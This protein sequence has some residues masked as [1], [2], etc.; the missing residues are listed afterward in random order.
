MVSIMQAIFSTSIGLI[1]LQRHCTAAPGPL[2]S[3]GASHFVAVVYAWF[4]APYFFYDITSMFIVFQLRLQGR[5]NA[6]KSYY[7]INLSRNLGSLLSK[8]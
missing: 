1:L 8:L 3:Y 2:T 5:K 4:G 6:K 7:L